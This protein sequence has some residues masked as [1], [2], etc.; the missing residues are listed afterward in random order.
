LARDRLGERLEQSVLERAHLF[1][2]E[3]F[4]ERGEPR[5]IGEEGPVLT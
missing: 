3:P 5:E 1:G 2:I 4:G